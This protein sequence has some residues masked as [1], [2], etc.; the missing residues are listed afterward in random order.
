MSLEKEVTRREFLKTGAVG[1]G[2]V[3]SKIFEKIFPFVAYSE[4]LD[5]VEEFGENIDKIMNIALKSKGQKLCSYK[6]PFDDGSNF[7]IRFEY[8][9][10][11]SGSGKL[12]ALVWLDE[13]EW[14]SDKGLDEVSL[15]LYSTEETNIS[16]KV[17]EVNINKADKLVN[18][19]PAEEAKFIV[20]YIIETFKGK[21][22]FLLKKAFKIEKKDINDFL[23]VKGIV[24]LMSEEALKQ[25]IYMMGTLIAE[26]HV[27][28]NEIAYKGYGRFDSDLFSK[29]PIVRGEV[30]RAPK[31]VDI[32]IFE[33]EAS[34]VGWALLVKS[35][36]YIKHKDFRDYKRVHS[37]GGFFAPLNMK[38]YLNKGNN[39]K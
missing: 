5:G 24:K 22:Y 14:Y 39:L 4:K 11:R 17:Y 34:I 7:N 6:L 15:W 8:I 18:Y 10:G 23:S 36:N 12:R 26:D 1:I 28:S 19:W 31:A 2:M 29:G 38:K 25:K 13:R 21:G 32:E 3:W 33:G 35:R 37:F 27:W 20:D 16:K 9:Y 30:Y